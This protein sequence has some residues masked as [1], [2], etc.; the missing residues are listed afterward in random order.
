MANLRDFTGKNRKFTGVSGITVSSGGN[1]GNRV[2]ETGRLRFNATTNL[3]EYY[4]GTDWKAIDA[5]PVITSFSI[6]S[7]AQTNVT[8]GYIDSAQA[9]TFDLSVNG[10]LFDT[11]GANVTL[12]G[13]GETLTPDT[14]VRNSANLLTATFT[15]SA[16]DT[17][18]DPYT[19]KVTNGSGLSAELVDA[20]NVDQAPVFTNAVDTVYS[21]FDSSRAS[22]TIAAAD[23]V[24]ATDAD[25]DTITYS[26]TAGALPTGCTLTAS[27]GVIIWSSISAVGT[28]TTSTFTI[29][30]ATSKGTSTRQFKITVKA[31]IRTTIT[32]TGA[33]T[34]SVP[35]GVTSLSIL[36]VAGGGSGGSSLGSG[37]GAG[38]MLEGTIAVTPGSSI[39]YTVGAGGSQGQAADYF[40]GYY[41]A[42]T[43]FGPIPGPGAT[44]TANGGGYGCGHA[45]GGPKG[46]GSPSEQNTNQI[47]IGGT[48]GSGGGTGSADQ[49][50]LTGRGGYG[51]QGD[52]AG[53]TGYGND[54]GIGGGN[55][56][57]H[58]HNG[59]G[60]GGAG[61]V[62]ANPSGYNAGAGGVGRVSTASGSP[63]YYAGGGGGSFHPPTGGSVGSGGSG[64]GSSGS[65]SGRSN[66]G[67]TNTGGGSGCGAHPGAGS[68]SGGPGIII[69]N[70]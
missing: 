15:A 63:V 2:N 51:N 67:G 8:S 70:I 66:A 11:T 60:G 24:G 30:A 58:S 40:S 32:S 18:N 26:V 23:L 34:F 33:G 39:P 35:N 43:T 42:N 62:G 22:G 16:L 19:L 50:S 28:D 4:N 41:G 5:P 36:M 29:S 61:G 9:G 45:G 52:S 38:G 49:S 10:S 7:P 57:Q 55:N 21:I 12:T 65:S 14:L 44:A 20:I 69:V 64:G 37:A 13:T 46:S 68:G 56:T 1:T 3:L 59:G 27:T 48:G 17:G 6:D 31:P 47:N 54:G 25:G 53:L